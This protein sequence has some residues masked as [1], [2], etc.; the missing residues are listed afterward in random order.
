MINTLSQLIFLQL[1]VRLVL[2]LTRHLDDS[3]SST[4]DHI[5]ILMTIIH[6]YYFYNITIVITII[7]YYHFYNITIVMTIINSYYIYKDLRGLW[8]RVQQVDTDV[9]RIRKNVFYFILFYLFTFILFHFVLF[10]FFI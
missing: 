8:K 2:Q 1:S 6:Y 3:R 7:H 5:S 10:S 4:H 9:S